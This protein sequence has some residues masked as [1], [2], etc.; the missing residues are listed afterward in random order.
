MQILVGNKNSLKHIM[1]VYDDLMTYL[2]EVK[3]TLS[4]S[5]YNNNTVWFV[6]TEGV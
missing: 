2:P 4:L 3:N 6:N 1:T 5:K